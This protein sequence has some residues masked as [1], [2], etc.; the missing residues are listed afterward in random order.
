MWSWRCRWMG[1][2]SRRLP[3][4]LQA[5]F[6][7]R[8]PAQ[9]FMLPLARRQ[10]GS[11]APIRIAIRRVVPHV[12]CNSPT[13][14]AALLTCHAPSSWDASDHWHW[15]L[16]ACHGREQ[17]VGSLPAVM[18]PCSSGRLDFHKSRSSHD[19]THWHACFIVQR[20]MGCV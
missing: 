6:Q 2:R 7:K 17:N 12:E 4:R 19:S 10:V 15:L 13:S 5:R 16:A 14:L 1:S 3:S 9:H 20:A 18:P 8:L 11:S